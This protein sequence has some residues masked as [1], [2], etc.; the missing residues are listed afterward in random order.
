[1]IEQ[2]SPQEWKVVVRIGLCL[3]LEIELDMDDILTCVLLLDRKD[4]EL[5]LS[6][7]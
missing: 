6:L 1:M 4:T 7:F 5:E 3:H 2:K